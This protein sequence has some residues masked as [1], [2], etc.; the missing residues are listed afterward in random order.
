MELARAQFFE[1]AGSDAKATFILEP[2]GRNTAPA[3]ALAAL[4]TSSSISPDELMLIAPADHEV[5]NEEAYHQAVER[6]CLA[7]SV[8]GLATFGINPDH[9]ETG[10]GYI[11]AGSWFKGLSCIDEGILEVRA[12]HEKPSLDKAIEYLAAGNFFWNSGIFVFKASTI[13]EE[14]ECHASTLI[15]ACWAAHA[16]AEVKMIHES[17][18]LAIH[19]DDMMLIPSVSLDYAVM[20]KSKRVAVVP[21][22]MGWNDLGSFDAVHEVMRRDQS[23]NALPETAIALDCSNCLVL[24]PDLKVRISGINDLV[25]VQDGDRLLIVKRGQTQ[26]VKSLAEADHAAKN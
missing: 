2:I 24:T 11:E 23:G 18:L 20:E 7:A 13:L 15:N 17:R 26:S 25:V 5:A 6:A 16:A 22:S 21:V 4:E 1:V 9:P 8:G 14:L 10:Y 19:A 3:V 12:F